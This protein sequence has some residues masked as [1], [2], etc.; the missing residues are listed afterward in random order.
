LV[1]RNLLAVLIGLLLLASIAGIVLTRA[2]AVDRP[3]PKRNT[4]SISAVDLRPTA[5][6]LE[7][8][9]RNI[10]RAA[11]RYDVKSRLLQKMVALVHGAAPQKA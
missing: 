8:R 11:L 7:V 1:R 9:V 10:T 5:G 6:G 4:A 2:A 3:D